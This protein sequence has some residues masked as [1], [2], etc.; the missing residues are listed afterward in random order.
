VKYWSVRYADPNGPLVVS[1]IRAAEMV[2]AER[3]LADEFMAER[4]AA[5][6][7]CL[8]IKEGDPCC[9]MSP[10]GDPT[11]LHSAD[12]VIYA[13]NWQAAILAA[14]AKHKAEQD[15]VTSRLPGEKD[16]VKIELDLLAVDGSRDMCIISGHVTVRRMRLISDLIEALREQP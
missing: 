8:E 10:D 7:P 3:K 2:F 12:C 5:G 14:A 1:G 11:G 9:K 16:L 15:R 4:A 13:R 6:K